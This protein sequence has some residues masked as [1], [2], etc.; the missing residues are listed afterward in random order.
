[1]W[2][3]NYCIP[4]GETGITDL[5][6]QFMVVSAGSLVNS[7]AAIDTGF[8]EDGGY[9]YFEY[10]SHTDGFFGMVKFYKASAPS[11]TL[12]ATA[13]NPREAENLDAKVSSGVVLS[14]A[15]MQAI[16]DIVNARSASHVE[17]IAER[18]SNAELLLMLM[19]SRQTAADEQTIYKTDG[20]TVFGTRELETDATAL[21]ITGVS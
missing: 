18:Y 3:L 9:Y 6:A 10:A 7:G 17:D 21:P 19:S 13:I 16:A 2:S 12:G 20:V 15:V 11:V 14:N 8:Y 4:I 1:M 5:R